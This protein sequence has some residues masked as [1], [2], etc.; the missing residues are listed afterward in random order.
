[1]RA[2]NSSSY[3]YSSNYKCHVDFVEGEDSKSYQRVT[4]CVRAYKKLR[5]LYDS[6][7]LVERNSNSE[8]FN[9]HLSISAAERDQIQALNR[10]FVERSL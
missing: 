8:T 9:T 2:D 1:M 3:E 10:K 6:L 4:S 7:L 5:G